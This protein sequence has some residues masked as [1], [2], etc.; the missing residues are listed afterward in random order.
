MGSNSRRKR[1]SLRLRK[2]IKALLHFSIVSALSCDDPRDDGFQLGHAVGLALVLNEVDKRVPQSYNDSTTHF[3]L[4]DYTWAKRGPEGIRDAIRVD[5]GEFDRLL[6]ALRFTN[7][8][9]TPRM[10]RTMR[11]AGDEKRGMIFD[12]HQGL[13]VLLLRLG[14]KKKLSDLAAD[15]GGERGMVYEA[16]ISSIYTA[17]RQYIVNEFTSKPRCF[18]FRKSKFYEYP[19][20]IWRKRNTGLMNCI[21]FIDGT[22][23]EIPFPRMDLENIC[24]SGYKKMH[25]I[26]C[27]VMP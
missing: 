25:S 26:R 11:R 4:D 13:L 20:A 2:A 7:A 6:K 21:G 22:D 15:L 16:R 5:R 23:L 10:F 1:G 24:Y 27:R 3:S 12:G 14:S 9:G 19:N 17:M 8:D 18:R